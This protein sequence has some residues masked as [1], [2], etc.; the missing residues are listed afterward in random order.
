MTA[1][2]DSRRLDDLHPA[3]RPRAERLLADAHAAAIPLTVTCTLRSMGAQARLHAQG[4]TVPGKVVTNARPGYSFH[5]YGLAIDVVPSELVV[6]PDWGETAAHRAR[7]T[8]LWRRVG[9]IGRAAGLTWGGDFVRLPDRPHFEW[10]G[11]LT[12]AQLRA[13]KRPQ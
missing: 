7:A 13:G 12:L 8:A 11:G 5:N 10:S 9:A 6:L 3:M 4:R 2:C 1:A